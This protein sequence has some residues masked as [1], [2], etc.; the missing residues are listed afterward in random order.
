MFSKLFFSENCANYEIM[1]KN[2][3]KRENPQAYKTPH[4]LCILQY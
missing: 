4:A 3:V 2:M 1:W